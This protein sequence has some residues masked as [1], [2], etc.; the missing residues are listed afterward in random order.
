MCF[1]GDTGKGQLIHLG[2]RK[3]SEKDCLREQDAVSADFQ[4]QGL[5]RRAGGN[6]RQMEH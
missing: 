3:M 6:S 4:E 1:Q 5:K 2:E